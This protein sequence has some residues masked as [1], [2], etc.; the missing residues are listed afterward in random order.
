MGFSKGLISRARIKKK[1]KTRKRPVRDCTF[2]AAMK[3]VITCFANEVSLYTVLKKHDL[4]LMQIKIVIVGFNSMSRH[5][6]FL[7]LAQQGF[8]S[9]LACSESAASQQMLSTL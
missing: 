4:A 8:C 5:V 3:L 2:T 9:D 7:T 1:K 6:V